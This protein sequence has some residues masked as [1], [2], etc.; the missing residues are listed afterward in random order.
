MLVRRSRTRCLRLIG[1]S[2]SS[3]HGRHRM[4]RLSCQIGISVACRPLVRSTVLRVS[5]PAHVTSRWRKHRLCMRMIMP[6]TAAKSA[7]SRA[8]L[9]ALIGCAPVKRCFDTEPMA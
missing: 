6:R 5:Q 1:M 4:R 8:V 7:A 3:E 9:G 2:R